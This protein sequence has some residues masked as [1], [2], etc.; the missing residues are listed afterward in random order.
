MAKWFEMFLAVLDMH[1]HSSSYVEMQKDYFYLTYE[2]IWWCMK[3]ESSW[4]AEY[5]ETNNF[6]QRFILEVARINFG[7]D[8][9]YFLQFHCP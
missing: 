8:L 6:H 7:S 1:I 9:Q 2:F 4:N 3:L 5:F